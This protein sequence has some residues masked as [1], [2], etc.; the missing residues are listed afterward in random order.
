M[1]RPLR[2]VAQAAGLLGGMHR[3]NA[4]KPGFVLSLAMGGITVLASGLAYAVL[5]LIAFKEVAR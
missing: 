4:R 5:H 1:T 3:A 2:L